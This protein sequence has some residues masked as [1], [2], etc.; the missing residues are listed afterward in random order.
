MNRVVSAAG[1][2]RLQIGF[3]FVIHA[4]LDTLLLEITFI[5]FFI[6]NMRGIQ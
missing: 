1:L 5:T 2:C 6:S 3:V 4:E